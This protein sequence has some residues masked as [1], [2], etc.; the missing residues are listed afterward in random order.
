VPRSMVEIKFQTPPTILLLMVGGGGGGGDS[1]ML[2][3]HCAQIYVP[4]VGA[5]MNG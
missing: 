1:R 4:V 2:V 5:P 3:K